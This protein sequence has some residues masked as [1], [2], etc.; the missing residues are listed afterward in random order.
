MTMKN[1]LNILKSDDITDI[2]QIGL[3]SMKGNEIELIN[4]NQ[5][6]FIAFNQC[7]V[8]IEAK[9]S[10]ITVS[11][12]DVIDYK[13]IPEI[14]DMPFY[15][16]SIIKLLLVDDDASNRIEKIITFNEVD[17]LEK[18]ITCE[19]LLFQI[20]NNQSLFFD[21]SYYWG[22]NVGGDLQLQEWYKNQSQRSICQN[23]Y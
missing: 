7:Y 9:D 14:E 2:V 17:D 1:I 5:V 13:E 12:S 18:T 22:I 10:L 21:A 4:N 3:V 20:S 16:N 19:A 8:K 6:F 23:I 11:K 15:K